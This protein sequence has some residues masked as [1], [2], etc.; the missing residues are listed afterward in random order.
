MDT[1]VGVVLDKSTRSLASLFDVTWVALWINI[2]MILFIF[3]WVISII[4]TTKDIIHRTSSFSLQIVSVV[5]VTLLT[6]LVW[7]P[8]YFL[9]RPLS[10]KN[11]RIP[12]REACAS[13]LVECYNCHTLNPKEYICCVAC[14]ERL[15]V[16]CKECWNSYSHSFWYCNICWAPNIDL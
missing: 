1:G 14:G 4:W 6:P 7:L 16:K 8:L 11:D 5:L 10:Y 12:R 15:K 13:N 2:L 3:L 9:I